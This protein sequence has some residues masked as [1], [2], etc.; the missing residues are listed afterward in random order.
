MEQTNL[1]NIGDSFVL[2]HHLGLGD[3]II[4]NGLV[5]FL[6]K[7]YKNIFLPVKENL[8]E[9]INYLYSEN[10]KISTFCIKNESRDE[11]ILKFADEN[12]LKILKLGFESVGTASFNLAFYKQI[13]LPYRY[14]YKYF[15][16][17]YANDKEVE[18]KEHLIKYYNVDP[19]NY[20]VVHNE[21]QWPGGV[22]DLKG[23]DQ[24]NAI[25]VTRESDI[26]KNLFL[27]RRV[28]QDA[29]SIHCINSSFLH[30]VERVKTNAKLHYHH[31]RK[32]RM[33]LSN[34]WT[35]VDYEN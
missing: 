1:K 24:S 15:Q 35:Y 14:T 30:L 20:S 21:Y 9:K 2:H 26:F 28:I 31:L 25:F 16:L 29:T 13:G 4:C 23:V 12:K 6:S 10:N 5:N 19:N 34:K 17:P 8:L 33:H 7:K 18:L 27:Y 32:N 3:S 11:D 22:F